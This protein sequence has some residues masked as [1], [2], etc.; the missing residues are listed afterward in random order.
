MNDNSYWRRMQ[1]GRA[2]ISRRA[3]I[4]GAAV[5]GGMVVAQGT[6]LAR[7]GTSSAASMTSNTKAPPY[8]VP[9]ANGVEFVPMVTTGDVVG[10]NYRMIGVPDG[11]GAYN[12]ADGTFSLIMNHELTNVQG[13]V[14]AHGSKGSMVSRFKISKSLD[15][16]SGED[17]INSPR[18]VHQ[19]DATKGAYFEGTTVWQRFCSADLPKPSALMNG[20]NGTRS[21]STSTAKKSPRAAAGLTSLRDR[22]RDAASAA[23]IRQPV[24]REHRAEPERERPDDRYRL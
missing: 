2:R 24:L 7:L 8:L 17:M 22:G 9:L 13:G 6:G 14:R 5:A 10:G 19:W 18:H 23:S 16:T 4:R 3:L 11:L 1:V 21:G 20:G 12:N 15:V